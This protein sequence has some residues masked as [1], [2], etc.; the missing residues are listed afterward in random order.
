MFIEAVV[1]QRA[2]LTGE[3]STGDPDA[4]HELVAS[5]V[6]RL[7][8][9]AIGSDAGVARAASELAE[10]TALLAAFFQNLDLL[11]PGPD[12]SA[13]GIALMVG[14]AVQ[15]LAEMTDPGPDAI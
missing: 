12:P 8:G 1:V 14:A 6:L 10:D 9:S 5:Q 15:R 3:V 2:Q 4:A 7:I 13:D 11:P